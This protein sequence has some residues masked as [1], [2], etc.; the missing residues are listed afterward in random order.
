MC[1]CGQCGGENHD[2]SQTAETDQTEE[3]KAY[4]EDE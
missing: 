1:C 4:S 3:Q 2:A